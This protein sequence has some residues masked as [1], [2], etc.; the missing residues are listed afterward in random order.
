ML[1][2]QNYYIRRGLKENETNK[3]KIETMHSAVIS[4]LST[5]HD[6]EN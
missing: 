1:F 4:K 5:D 2:I 6:I 3:E